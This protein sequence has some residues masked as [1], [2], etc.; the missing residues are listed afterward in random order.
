[1]GKTEKVQSVIGQ[2]ECSSDNFTDTE[3]KRNWHRTKGNADHIY[4]N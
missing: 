1:M 2:K 4:T 3:D